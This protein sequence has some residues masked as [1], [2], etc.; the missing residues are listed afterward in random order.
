MSD[1]YSDI[2]YPVYLVEI[3]NYRYHVDTV[4]VAAGVVVPVL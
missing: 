2:P 1:A 4:E 3:E